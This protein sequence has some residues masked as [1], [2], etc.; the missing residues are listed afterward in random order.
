M[1]LSTRDFSTAL[2]K[3][4]LAQEREIDKHLLE[5]AAIR[6]KTSYVVTASKEVVQILISRY[7]KEGWD[8]KI[9]Y[10]GEFMFRL[11]FV[12]PEFKK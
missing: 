9:G 10:S 3:E 2:I 5:H 1:T 4:V 8:V 11:D 12:N 6:G 7:L